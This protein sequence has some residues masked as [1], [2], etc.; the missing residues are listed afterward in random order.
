MSTLL[1]VFSSFLE[2]SQEKLVSGIFFVIGGFERIG[3]VSRG[4]IA[5]V[6]AEQFTVPFITRWRF[7]RNPNRVRAFCLDMEIRRGGT[8]F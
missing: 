2:F 7:P 3:S 6:V 8:R 1:P 5:D 4:L